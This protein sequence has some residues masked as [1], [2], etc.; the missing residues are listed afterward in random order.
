MRFSISGD[1]DG[2]IALQWVVER[3][4]YPFANGPLEYLRAHDAFR[5][6][7]ADACL[8]QQAR[9]YVDSYLRRKGPTEAR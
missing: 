9:A 5:E 4:H 6:A 7:P 8:A 3:G 2:V 1:R